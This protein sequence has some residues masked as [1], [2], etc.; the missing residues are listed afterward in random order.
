M[1]LPDVDCLTS[2]WIDQRVN[3]SNH[4]DAKMFS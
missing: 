4:N 2:N 3:L 1:K